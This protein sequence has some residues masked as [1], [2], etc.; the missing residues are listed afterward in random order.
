VFFSRKPKNKPVCEYLRNYYLN[1]FESESDIL[2]KVR[3]KRADVISGYLLK[4]P[5]YIHQGRTWMRVKL[6]KWKIGFKFGMFSATKKPFHYKSKK[7][8]NKR[9]ARR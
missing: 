1:L 3:A 8:A 9:D 4:K 7:K 6:H 5:V 2:Y